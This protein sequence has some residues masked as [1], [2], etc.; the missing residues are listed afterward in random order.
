MILL[1]F[2]IS[3]IGLQLFTSNF[4]PFLKTGITLADLSCV[5]NFPSLKD[6]LIISASGTLRDF[7]KFLEILVGILFAPLALLFFRHLI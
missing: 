5:G 1:I 3:D 7:R 2:D 4:T 6:K